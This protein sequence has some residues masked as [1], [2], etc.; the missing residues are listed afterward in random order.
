VPK[1]ILNNKICLVLLLTISLVVGCSVK[2]NTILSV[3][4]HGMLV[5]YNYFFN[6]RERM[7]Q[8]SQALADAH[9]DKYDRVLSIFKY[10][11]LNQAK[12]VFGDMDE[13]IK[14][15]SIAISRN[16]MDLKSKH[17]SKTMERNN[18]IDDCYLLIGK[19]QFYKHDYWTAIETFQYTSSEYKETPSRPEALL[20]LTKTYLELGKNV[21]ALYLLDFL[22]NDKKFPIALKGEYNATLAHYHFLKNDMPRT[23]D[24][25]QAAT[26]TTKNKEKRARY[27]FII[28]QL[29]QKRGDLDSAFTAYYNVIKLNPP[30]DMAF[31]ARINRALCY[32]PNSGIAEDVKKELSKMLKDEKN[33]E[34][35]DQIYYALAGIARQEKQEVLAIEYLNKSLRA[36]A[37]NDVQKGL[38]HLQLTSIYYQKPDYLNAAAYCDSA[39]SF[40]SN[41]HPDYEDI[42][43]RRNSLDRLVQN[44]RIINDE[45]SLQTLAKMSPVELSSKLDEVL[46][47]EDA[48]KERIKR[49]EA[50]K[51]KLE[52]QE[53]LAEKELKSTPKSTGNTNSATAQGSWYFYNQSAISF[54]FNDFLTKWGRRKLE[55]NWRRKDKEF[56]LEDGPEVVDSSKAKT[57]V[58]TDS[59][60]KLDPNGRKNALKTQLP[61]SEEQITASN[62]RLIE[63]YYNV[64]VIYREQLGNLKESIRYFE[65]LD[66]KFPDNKFKK[67]TYYNLYRTYMALE[68]S[69][70]ANYY[71]DYLIKFY[72]ESEYS[73]LIQNPNFFKDIKRKTAVLEVFYENTYRAYINGQYEDVIERKTMSDSLFPPNNLTPKFTL[74][75]ALAI[76]KLKSQGEFK[77]A[78]E[79][80]VSAYPKDSVSIKANEILAYIKAKNIEVSDTTKIKQIQQKIDSIAYTFDQNTQQYFILLYNKHSLVPAEVIP[81]IKAFNTVNYQ[82]KS[83]IVSNGTLNLEKDYISVISFPNYQ[84][85]IQYY[86]DILKENGVLSLL[87]ANTVEFFIISR[88]NLALMAKTSAI[89]EYSQFFKKNYL[90]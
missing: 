58:N 26:A 22:K 56:V 12:A 48:E 10:G 23:I 73:K 4:Y 19:C 11:D 80:V 42:K 9:V 82:M 20:W 15:V 66:T 84:D 43:A 3:N 28:G 39:L 53:I 50:E 51:Q 74:L 71:K 52:Q 67:P 8:G 18:W 38:T 27:H 76:G 65:L 49:E 32:D 45:D 16:S 31:N 34:Y 13:A 90:Q 79:D 37:G 57:A 68:D 78:L 29:Y 87:D 5:H 77:A 25:L 36:S 72:P 83:L 47:K 55:D 70:K 75:K 2:K 60:A 24:A 6:A 69:T 64:A 89:K 54:G 88:D 59:I 17:D 21:D 85:A 86:N 63:A 40:M 44:L 46:A 7:N 1:S 33:T 30:Y 41:D 14:K 61:T 35:L 81:K 62:T